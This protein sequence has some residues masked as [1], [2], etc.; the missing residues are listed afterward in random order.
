M[1]LRRQHPVLLGLFI[2]AGIFFLFAGGISL[3]VSSL[4]SRNGTA[5]LFSSTNGIGVVELKGL[6]TSPEETIAILTDFRRNDKIR[7]IVL[8]VD[9]PGGAVGAAQEI[10]AEVRR[11][12]KVK[13]VIAS[14]GS[15]AASGGYYAAIGAARIFASPG[16][17][18]GSI[19][20]IV[21][22]ANLKELF[23]KIGYKSDVVKSGALKDIGATNRPMSPAERALLQGVVDSIH[24]QFV[25]DVVEQ[26]ALPEKKVRELADG[27]I[28]SGQQ[29]LEL[30]MIDELGNFTDAV[31]AAARL[32]GVPGNETPELIYPEHRTTLLDLIAT[33]TPLKILDSI[34]QTQPVLAYQWTGI[35]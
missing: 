33:K 7:A 23:A 18:T 2:L 15:V 32:G 31:L 30:G 3:L 26:R 25:L 17:I 12:N 21:K 20:V 34:L 11:T 8:R 22:F 13:P 35:Q 14:M 9:S 6:I 1:Q 4:T 5:A 24:S 10:Y 16:T 28:F 19:G 27:R 29:A